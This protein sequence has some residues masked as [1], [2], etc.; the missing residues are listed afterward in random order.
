MDVGVAI[1][2]NGMNMIPSTNTA[3]TPKATS[4]PLIHRLVP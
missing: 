3:P 1:G 4:G 2:Q